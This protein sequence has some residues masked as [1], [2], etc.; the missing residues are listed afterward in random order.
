MSALTRQ[1][2]AFHN[3]G[4]YRVRTFL[5]VEGRWQLQSMVPADHRSIAQATMKGDVVNVDHV[6]L[7][8]PLQCEACNYIAFYVYDAACHGYSFD[9]HHC[10][11]RVA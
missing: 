1:D 10:T 5:M 7:D 8:E 6:P 9:G 11:E 3:D 2:V 4:T